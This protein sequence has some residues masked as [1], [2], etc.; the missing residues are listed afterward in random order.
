MAESLAGGGFHDGLELLL[1][2]LAA[3]VAVAFDE[4]VPLAALVSV[5]RLKPGAAARS[6]GPVDDF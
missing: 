6:Y 4:R 1:L 3:V 2:A 5:G